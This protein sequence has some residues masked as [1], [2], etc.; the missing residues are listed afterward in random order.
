M[1]KWHQGE[2]VWCALEQG[3]QLF[4]VRGETANVL[5]SIG[6]TGPLVNIHSNQKAATARCRPLGEITLAQGFATCGLDDES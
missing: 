4:P 2:H 6:H 1:T 5:D 3:W